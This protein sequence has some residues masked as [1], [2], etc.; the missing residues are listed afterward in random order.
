MSFIESINNA[1]QKVDNFCHEVCESFVQGVQELYESSPLFSGSRD[2]GK[3]ED[4]LI[5]GSEDAIDF[6]KSGDQIKCR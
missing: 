5:D 1:K 4:M 3:R 6:V 2:S